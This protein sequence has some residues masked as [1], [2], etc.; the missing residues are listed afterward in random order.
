MLGAEAGLLSKAA[1]GT[2]AALALTVGLVLAAVLGVG[3]V[4]AQTDW[5]SRPV[6]IIIPY[7]A[8]ASTDSLVRGIAEKLQAAL[9]QPFVVENRGGAAGALGTELVAKAAPDGYTI[10]MSPQAPIVVLP[11]LRTM[12]YDPLKDFVH[13][14]RL[15]ESIAGIAVHPSVGAKTLAEFIALA[16]KSPGKFTFV[17]AGVGTV[18]HLRGEMLKLLAG[19]DLLHIPYKGTGEALADL[20]AG[21]VSL[22]FES[23]VFP[24]VK[25]G[26]LVLLA[27][28]DERNPEFP[29]VPNMKEAGF[30][31]FDLPIWT[32]AYLP[33]GTPPAIVEKLHLALAKIHEDKE[34]AAKL[35]AAGMRLYPKT[36]SLSE[37]ADRLASEATRFGDLIKK[38]NVKL[39]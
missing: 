29:D 17:S 15:G 13:V 34:L 4:S 37:L 21:N 25:S 35:E 19:I 6:R 5:P 33:R 24:H 23:S 2:M 20:L 31:E 30:P 10:L 1:R 38:A 11:H 8:G 9:N 22:M 12:A 28:L 27:M 3:S 18:N 14:D 39:D 16:K 32:G 36:G 26:K 7:A